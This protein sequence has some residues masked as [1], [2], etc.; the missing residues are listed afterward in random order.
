MVAKS[1]DQF[2]LLI[3]W[4][5]SKELLMFMLLSFNRLL[6]LLRKVRFPFLRFHLKVN[7]FEML[8]EVV[9]ELVYCCERKLN[10]LKN[11]SWKCANYR[12]HRFEVVLFHEHLGWNSLDCGVQ[13]DFICYSYSLNLREVIHRLR[14]ILRCC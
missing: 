1:T 7:V 11:G 4:V 2:S 5:D 3:V 12:S 10:Y 8:G 9:V 13:V 14:I 6:N